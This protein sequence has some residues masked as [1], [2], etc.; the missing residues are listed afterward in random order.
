MVIVPTLNEEE[1]IGPTLRELRKVLG[2]PYL[3]IV[4]GNSVDDT[5]NIAKD[6]GAK[7]IL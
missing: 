6:L 4:D 3:L 1:G 5:V 7:V 2:D